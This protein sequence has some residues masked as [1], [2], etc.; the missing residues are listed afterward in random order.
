MLF[1]LYH[2]VASVWPRGRSVLVVNSGFCL[3]ELRG[4]HRQVGSLAGAAHLLNDNTGVLS[5]NTNRESVA[6]R[7]FSSFEF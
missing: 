4:R 6:Y 5:M 3:G 1:Y 7:S 2:D